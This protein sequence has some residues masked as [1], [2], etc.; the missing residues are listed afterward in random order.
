MDG[1]RW[2]SSFLWRA[3]KKSYRAHEYEAVFR[4]TRQSFSMSTVR[5]GFDPRN[6][7]ATAFQTLWVTQE[8]QQTLALSK[9]ISLQSFEIHALCIN[10]SG[11]TPGPHSGDALFKFK[12][13]Y[14]TDLLV[15]CSL[16]S[17]HI[18]EPDSSQRAFQAWIE[19][20]IRWGQVRAV[21]RVQHDFGSWLDEEFAG[22]KQCMWTGII[23][24]KGEGLQEF[25]SP[26]SGD[27]M[28]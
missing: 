27:G 23:H 10:A 13:C 14:F 15:H 22:V 28:T 3:T 19:P 1:P 26:F 12:G 18:L 21:G 9:C 17:R 5:V 7:S 2:E 8:C 20:E 11:P 6:E 16:E 24:V 4:S 25:L